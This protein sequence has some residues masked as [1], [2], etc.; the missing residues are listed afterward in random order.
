MRS[1]YQNQWTAI[2]GTDCKD[3]CEE[4]WVSMWI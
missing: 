3:S 2:R 4:H 1:R